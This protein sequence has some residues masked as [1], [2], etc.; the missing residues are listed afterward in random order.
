[1]GIDKQKRRQQAYQRLVEKHSHSSNFVQGLFRA[2]WVGGVICVIGQCF[3]DLARILF[4]YN[5]AQASGFAGICLIFI[6]AVLTGLG[7]FDKLGQYA[8][9]GTIVPITGFANS[10]I[11][12]AL[13]FKKEG[14]VLGIGAKLYVIAGPVLTYGISTA[15]VL[16]LLY[17]LYGVIFP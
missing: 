3:A 5:D 7:I 15:A 9:G 16:G 14:F 10:V 12:P 1:M 8:G 11:S 6:T 17:F 2:F 13:E 4:E